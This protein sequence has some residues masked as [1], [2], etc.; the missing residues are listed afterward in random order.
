MPKLI[1][2]AKTAVSADASRFRD[3]ICAGNGSEMGADRFTASGDGK[4]PA[5]VRPTFPA[6]E[7]TAIGAGKEA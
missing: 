2:L 1:D 3:A 6:E 5:P 7:T 4:V